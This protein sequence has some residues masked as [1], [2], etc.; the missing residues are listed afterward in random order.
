MSIRLLRKESLLVVRSLD[1]ARDDSEAV[2]SPSTA[3]RIA[4]RMTVYGLDSSTAFHFA[5]NDITGMDG[6]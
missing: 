6:I 1:V 4:S 3:L 2:N 5:Q